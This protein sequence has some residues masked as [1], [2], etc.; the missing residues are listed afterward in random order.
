MK[1]PIERDRKILY[2]NILEKDCKDAYENIT[3]YYNVRNFNILKLKYMRWDGECLTHGQRPYAS[4]SLFD[5]D[6]YE[7]IDYYEW[8]EDYDYLISAIKL[9]LY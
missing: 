6:D 1:K 7:I 9:N 4:Y 3:S 2:I 5:A 8:L